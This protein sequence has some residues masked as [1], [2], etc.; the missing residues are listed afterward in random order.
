[1]VDRGADTARINKLLF[2]TVSRARMQAESMILSTLEF[3]CGGRCAMITVPR[4]VLA[5]TGLTE[6]DLEGIPGIPIRI[7]GVLA[8]VTVKEKEDGEYKISLR[9]CDCVDASAVCGVFGGGGHRNAAG[10]T[11]NGSLGE[12]KSRLTAAIAAVM[13]SAMPSAIPADA[14]TPG[15]EAQR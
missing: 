6:P 3:Y 11:L 8:G 15:P 1:M 13:P 2:D 12:V 4:E 5:K 10:C 14:V 7:E 9:T